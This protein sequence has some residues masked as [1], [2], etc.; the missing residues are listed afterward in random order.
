MFKIPT[1]VYVIISVISTF[2]I[3]STILNF[4]EITPDAYLIYLIFVSVIVIFY[5]FLPAQGSLI[6]S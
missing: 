1:I 3:M 5:M 2:F 6:F 4:F